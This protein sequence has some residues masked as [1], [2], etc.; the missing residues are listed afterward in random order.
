M[1]GG[2]F[3]RQT[4]EIAMFQ[5]RRAILF[6]L[7]G[8]GMGE[9]GIEGTVFLQQRQGADR[10][11]AGH[12]RNIIR[13]IA[14]QGEVIDDLFGREAHFALDAI[15]IEPLDPL[16]AAMRIV[17]EGVVIDQLHQI[18]VAGDE[19]GLQIVAPR[20]PGEG[21]HDIIRL[22]TRLANQRKVQR[23]EEL[24]ETRQLFHH[25]LG[26]GGALRL[27]RFIHL[28]PESRL[29]GIKNNG[30]IVGRFLLKQVET[31]ARKTKNDA[32]VFTAGIDQRITGK[33]KIS[34]IGKR[35]AIDK[36]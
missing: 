33:G 5:E 34:A 23:L 31:D 35:C 16:A 10:S 18:L 17:D 29:R 8:I 30:E 21:A 28:M 3:L 22:E 11:D 12:A 4:G 27:V 36:K 7:H 6:A 24:F 32:D 14:G 2:Q 26:H 9:N 20:L 19:H 1:N 25:I 13:S 15:T